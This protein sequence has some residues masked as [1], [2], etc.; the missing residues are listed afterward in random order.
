MAKTKAQN[1]KNP[2]P[3]ETYALAEK[4]HHDEKTGAARPSEEN[5]VI[6]REWSKE[7]KL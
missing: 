3:Y 5:V 1:R 6:M 2:K 7:H 4:A